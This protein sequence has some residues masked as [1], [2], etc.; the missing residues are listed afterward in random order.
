MH[1]SK[2]GSN[3]R[4]F[5]CRYSSRGRIRSFPCLFLFPRRALRVCFVWPAGL[6][7]PSLSL[8]VVAADRRVNWAGMPL[9]MLLNHLMGRLMWQALMPL[10]RT[11][12]VRMPM[13]R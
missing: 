10:R 4:F 6:P 11:S 1:T 7:A 8:R 13:Q 5:A 2:C 12:P 9:W 3:G